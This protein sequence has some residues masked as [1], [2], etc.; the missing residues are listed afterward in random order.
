MQISNWKI[1]RKLTAGFSLVVLIIAIVGILSIVQLRTIEKHRLGLDHDTKV[2]VELREA[3]F[4]LTRQENSFRGWVITQ[5]P[6]YIERAEKHRGTFLEHL[7][8]AVAGYAD[9]P[10]K[11]A[12]LASLRDLAGKWH[13]SVVVG[14]QKLIAQG[15]GPSS[16]LALVGRDGPSD[17]LI[18]PAEDVLE[19]LIE[20]GISDRKIKN[21]ALQSTVASATLILIAGII[22]AGIM[23][24]LL[25]W[26]LTRMIARPIVATTTV[27]ESLAA[28]D[29]TVDVNGQDR[30]DEVGMMAKAVQVFKDN[31][32]AKIR[33]DGEIEAARQA[34]EAERHR[35]EA[36]L[37]EAAEQQQQVVSGVASGL[38]R[39]SSGELTFRL[40][41][42]FAAE[43]E[44]LRNDFNGA[45]EN[46]QDAMKVIATN[47]AGITAGAGEISQASDDL[48]R[49]T[50]Q[51][52]ASLEETAAALDEITATVKRTASGARQASETV[53]AAK[54][55]AEHSGVIV[56]EA[57]TAMGQIETSSQQISQIIG[58]IDEIAFQTN[59]L[60]LNAGVEAARAGDAGRGFAVV[61][62]EVRALAQRSAEAA[63][64]IKALISTSSK[65]VTQG[66]DLVGQ[67]GKALQSIVTKVAEID[68]LVSEISSSAQEQAT[69][70]NEVNTAVNQMDQV[71]QQNA[72]MV[73]ESTAA[74]HSLA[75]EAQEMSRLVSR[76]QV[77]DT[78]VQ[79]SAPKRATRQS[80]PVASPARELHRKVAV[81]FGGKAAARPA[82]DGWEE[83]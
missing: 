17:K 55:E 26:L 4:V 72:A 52:A 35:N 58:V 79:H 10:S 31:G 29:L 28:G 50:E 9:Q 56:N 21:E 27:M 73:E 8:A 13:D 48:S 45:M 75:Q 7:D 15:A 74:S 18:G 2:L 83:F 76:F 66:V 24:G 77:G 25:G 60:A 33:L 41:E 37:A 39:L 54:G 32:I 67:T 14:G 12:E 65:Q 53:T 80:A 62:Q 23:A 43:Y 69:G 61:A 46:L 70:L 6:Y 11:V 82:Q 34:S 5:D 20:E 22:S 36:I 49:R 68:A 71:V 59:L 81:S 51:Q 64:E 78:P 30:R 42:P 47:V 3:K 19:T 16:V 1:S 63:K 38:S 57:V 40:T 44:T